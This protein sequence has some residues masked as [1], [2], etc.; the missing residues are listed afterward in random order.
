MI[1]KQIKRHFAFFGNHIS[2]K[3]GQKCCP[4]GQNGKPLSQEV[5]R[6][7]LSRPENTAWQTD[8][9]HS[10]IYRIFYFRNVFKMTA[11]IKDLYELDAETS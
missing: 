10:R 7:F 1:S 8:A 6:Q 9:S 11:F 3:H 2:R 4:Y 5:V